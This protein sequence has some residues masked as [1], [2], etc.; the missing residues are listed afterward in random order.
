MPVFGLA[1]SQQCPFLPIV[2]S[3]CPH[4]FMRRQFCEVRTSLFEMCSRTDRQTDRHAHDNASR[5][6]RVSMSVTDDRLTSRSLWT[7]FALCWPNCEQGRPSKPPSSGKVKL[8][9]YYYR[10]TCDVTESMVTMRSPCCGYNTTWCAE[11]NGEDLSC[12][13]NKIES[14]SLRKCPYDLRSGN[15]AY[16]SAIAA[17]NVSP[18]FTYKMAAK[19]NWHRYGTK[20]RHCHPVH[21]VNSQIHRL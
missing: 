1:T 13:W 12:Y 14:V 18:S 16:L 15:K 10:V 11:L 20:L 6:Y 21:E 5:P 17:T 9:K 8:S 3:A 4:F 7:S 19:I 2:L